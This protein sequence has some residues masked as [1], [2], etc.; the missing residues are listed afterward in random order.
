MNTLIFATNNINKVVE[1]RSVL[2]ERFQNTI[3]F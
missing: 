3:P 2:G 1:I